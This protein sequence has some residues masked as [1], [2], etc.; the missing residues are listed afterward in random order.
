MLIV[1]RGRRFCPDV[2]KVLG[3]QISKINTKSYD[4]FHK[5]HRMGI[6]SIVGDLCVEGNRKSSTQTGLKIIKLLG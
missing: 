5:L 3:L 1:R 2:K 6:I 4:T